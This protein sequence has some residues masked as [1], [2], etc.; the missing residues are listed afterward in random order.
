MFKMLR[1]LKHCPILQSTRLRQKGLFLFSTLILV[2]LGFHYL[3]MGQKTNPLSN[4]S[5]ADK[6]ITIELNGELNRPGLFNYVK[7]PTVKQ[8]IQDAGGVVL[9]RDISSAEGAGILDYDSTL[10]V[11]AKDDRAVFLQI[12]PLSGKALW[13]LG[14]T[15]PLNRVTA[16]D[17]DRLPGI[18]PVMARRI[19][20]YR[21]VH[22]GFLTLDE[23]KEV[24]G[25][26]E[27]TFEKIKGYF[28]L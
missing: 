8:V 14:R 3:G 21:E 25:I 15:L 27:K 4:S 7:P 2:F 10:T 11:S 12:T 5:L 17:L 26:K 1:T 13:I 23:L 24:K 18:G 9:N 16:E 22:G 28:T 6:E 20:A 19:I